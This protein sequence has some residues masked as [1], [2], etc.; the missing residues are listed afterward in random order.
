MYKSGIN[1]DN[2]PVCQL[3]FQVNIAPKERQSSSL[4]TKQLFCLSSVFFPPTVEGCK[5]HLKAFTK[6]TKLRETGHKFF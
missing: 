3:L 6:F 1:S 2:Q 4:V 5:E